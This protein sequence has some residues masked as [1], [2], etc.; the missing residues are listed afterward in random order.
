MN[1]TV[2]TYGLWALKIVAALAFL[3]AGTAKFMSVPMM[4]ET[5]E[6]VGVGQ[7]FRYVTGTIEIAGAVL[8]F[9]PRKAFYGASLLAVTMVGAVLTHLVLI[10]GS[11]VP[12][13]FLLLITGTIAFATRE[14]F[15][16]QTA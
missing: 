3:A 12:A 4:V 5:F 6:N 8:L 11:P 1:D 16:Q 10:G 15:T 13:I 9:V 2:K 7:W 14:Q